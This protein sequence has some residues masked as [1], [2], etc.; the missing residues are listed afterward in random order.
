MSFLSAIPIAGSLIEKIGEAI[1]RNITTEEE[2]LKL[3]AEITSL[4][5]P[6]IAEAIKAQEA[7]AQLQAEVA[8]AEAQSEHFI[9]YARRPILSVLAFVNVIVASITHYMPIEYAYNLAL[10][11]NGLD[12]GTRGV[13]KMIRSFK[14]REK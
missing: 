2:R 8:K 1:D 3:K 5:V 10:L 4:Y 14:E 13:E 7:M 6:V 11:I 12:M 9:V